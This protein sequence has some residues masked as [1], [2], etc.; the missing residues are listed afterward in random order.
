MAVEIV[1]SEDPPYVSRLFDTVIFPCLIIVERKKQ[2]AS[3]DIWIVRAARVQDIVLRRYGHDDTVNLEDLSRVVKPSTCI[4]NNNNNNN[5]IMGGDV[6]F[7]TI[8]CLVAM[9][10]YTISVPRVYNNRTI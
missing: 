8:F 4:C 1:R 10:I 3:N 7:V 5:N 2:T 6:V 9:R